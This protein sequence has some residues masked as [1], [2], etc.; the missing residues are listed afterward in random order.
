MLPPVTGHVSRADNHSQ[1]QRPVRKLPEWS[2][3]SEMELSSRQLNGRE[4]SLPE[5]NKHTQMMSSQ[6]LPPAHAAEKWMRHWSSE[7][8]AHNWRTWRQSTDSISHTQSRVSAMPEDHS[9]QP[10]IDYQQPSSDTILW[11]S[12]ST[13]GLLTDTVLMPTVARR[14]SLSMDSLTD[15]HSLVFISLLFEFV[16]KCMHSNTLCAKYFVSCVLSISDF[17]FC[18]TTLKLLM[19][20]FTTVG[21]NLY[22]YSFNTVFNFQSRKN[23]IQTKFTLQWWILHTMAATS[24]SYCK[25]FRQWL[26]STGTIIIIY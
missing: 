4:M 1:Q 10:K 8:P 22:A 15:K 7:L 11:R 5:L 18:G 14:P 19:A 23:Y 6:R 3:Y 24:V 26:T 17:N 9:H 13:K 20:N 21:C 2:H 12:T 16:L 25:I